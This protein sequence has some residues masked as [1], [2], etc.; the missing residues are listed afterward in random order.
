[1]MYQVIDAIAYL[2]DIGI[3][4]RDLKPNNIMF[5]TTQPNAPL[6][7]LD[8]GFSKLVL[9]TQGV[10]GLVGTRKYFA[11]EMVLGES[12]HKPVDMWCYG[13][14]LYRL[15]TGQFPFS[16]ETVDD[17]FKNIAEARY[18][19]ID[20]SWTCLSFVSRDLVRGLFR[21]DPSSRLTAHE[22]LAHPFFQSCR[23]PAS[24]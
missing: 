8:F 3:V 24:S 13:V 11:P 22:A 5:E 6:K 16:G 12:H 21:C 10:H 23:E 14:I 9:P 18:E 1:M 17:L 7:T 4:H 2:R 15:L 19:R 20:V